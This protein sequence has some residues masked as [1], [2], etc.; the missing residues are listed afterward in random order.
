MSKSTK[1]TSGSRSQSNINMIRASVVGE[2]KMSISRF[3]QE[4]VL[5]KTT[6]WPVLRNDSVQKV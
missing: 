6:L 1:Y 3:S 5:S 4:V 2:T